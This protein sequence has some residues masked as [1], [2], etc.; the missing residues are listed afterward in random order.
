VG[1]DLFDIILCNDNYEN[2]IGSSEWVRTDEKTRSDPRSYCTDL[3]DD[4][5]PWRHDSLKL[6]QVILDIHYERTGPLGENRL[7]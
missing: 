5:H 6:A 7:Q 4:G 2:N 3:V 1:R